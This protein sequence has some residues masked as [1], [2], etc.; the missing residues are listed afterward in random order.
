MS[1]RTTYSD[2]DTRIIRKHVHAVRYP[3]ALGSSDS[4]HEWIG[5]MLASLRP[6][7]SIA[8]LAEDKPCRFGFIDQTVAAE[9]DALST[10]QADRTPNQAAQRMSV[11]HLSFPISREP[12]AAHRWL[13]RWPW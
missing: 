10:I 2:L 13:W 12:A 11:K 1:I 7:P 9:F 6:C 5:Q 4:R 3:I 8:C